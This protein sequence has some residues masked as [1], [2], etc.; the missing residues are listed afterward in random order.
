MKDLNTD[1]AYLFI[2]PAAYWV[3]SKTVSSIV[4]NFIS[5]LFCSIP[6]HALQQ[7]LLASGR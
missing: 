4:L 2:F 1:P 3:A 6:Y 7:F 5:S